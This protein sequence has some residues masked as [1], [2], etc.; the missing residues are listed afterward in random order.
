LVRVRVT[1]L[2][3]GSKGNAMVVE[4]EEDRILVDA[5]FAARTLVA[6]LRAAG[7]APE[8]ISALVLTHEHNDHVQ[9][10]RV[11]AKRFGWT[12]Y[13]TAGT[14]TEVPRLSDV[15]PVPMSPRETLALDTMRIGCLRIPHDGLDPVALVIESRATGARLG[16]AYDVG[17]VTPT[18]ERTLRDLDALVLE[19]NHDTEMLRNG[20]YPRSLQR[21]ISGGH[22][23]LSNDAAARL[24]AAVAHPGLRHVVL[25]HLSEQNNTPD[26]ARRT[27]GVALRR[28]PYDGTLTVAS[29]DGVV[30][31]DVSRSPRVE[32]IDLF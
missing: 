13:A 11:A 14:I 16:V 32:Q 10:A 19:S 23:H 30:R 1:V 5:G 8:S 31:F 25:A 6:R 18:L 17:H 20:P 4:C 15:A 28:T 22:G 9:G 2:G 26:V 27:V 12:V 29:Q 21:R 24:A 7:I 3:S